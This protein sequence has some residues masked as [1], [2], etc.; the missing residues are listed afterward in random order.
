MG[1]TYKHA[2]VKWD[3]HDGFGIERLVLCFLSQ[4]GVILDMWPR[5]IKEFINNI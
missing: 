4:C 3:M 1:I 2:D 5:E